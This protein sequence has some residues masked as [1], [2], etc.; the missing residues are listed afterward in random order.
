MILPLQYKY[1]NFS[2]LIELA[3]FRTYKPEVSE[4]LNPH[5]CY[6]KC[7]AYHQAC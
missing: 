7:L 1:D 3:F 4:N 2:L 6:R 5:R